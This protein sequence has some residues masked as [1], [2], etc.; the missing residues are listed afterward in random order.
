MPPIAAKIGSA[1]FFGFRSS[2]WRISFRISRPTIKKKI[3]IKP[4]LI[5]PWKGST[6]SLKSEPTGVLAIIN[7][8]T[9]AKTRKMPP[10][11][12]RAKNLR[13]CDETR[14]RMCES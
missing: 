13:S 4:S 6:A 2:P 9:E 5:K 7:A 12:S 11:L 3:A 10:E 1:A 14:R 8:I